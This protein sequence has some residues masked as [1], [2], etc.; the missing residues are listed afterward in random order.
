VTVAYIAGHWPAAQA[1]P[2]TALY[3]AGTVGGGFCGRLLAGLVAEFAGWR[4]ALVAL[5]VLQV[6]V[7]QAIRAGLPPEGPA[8]AP[9]ASGRKV[10][11]ALLRDPRLR[12]AYAV[13]FSILFALVGGFTYITLHLA[14]PPFNLGP[15]ALAGVFTVYLV[16]MFVTPLSGRV[17]NRIGHAQTL[18]AAWGIAIAG[19]AL[20]LLPSLAA[21][22]AGLALFSGGL[23]IVQTAATSFVGE[24]A[25]H[26]RATA[27]GLYVT[28]Y[29]LGGSAGGLLPAPL[30][31][32]G[33]W[34]AVALM[35]ALV[36][37][38]SVTLARRSLRPLA[39][40]APEST[41]HRHN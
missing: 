27:V 18:T 9:A 24:A 40:P 41:S 38:L 4:I 22:M 31:T 7:A 3:V 1:R 23:F 34:S 28:C 39:I 30:F 37:A 12:G 21:I 35:I 17:L 2:V 15:A 32:H 6:A 26:A 36:G 14:E 5:A 29:Y 20:T 10:V 11:R 13:G 8:H 19:L 16:G 25:P 33:G